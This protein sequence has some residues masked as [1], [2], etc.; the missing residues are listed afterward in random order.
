[1]GGA[2][3]GGGGGHD[4]RMLR[5][6]AG[7]VLAW[8]V[9][10][11]VRAQEFA[12]RLAEAASAKS[13]LGEAREGRSVEGEPLMVGDVDAES[14]I[15]THAPAEIVF[16]V[17]PGARWFTCWFGVAAE[18]GENGSIALEVWVDGER[19]HVSPVQRGGAAPVWVAVP[20]DG[21]KELKLVVTDGGDGNGADHGNLLWPRWSN[22]KDRPAP[23]QPVAITFAGQTSVVG[24][25]WSGRPARRFVEAYPLGDGRLGAV[26]YGGVARDR[27]VLNEITM[28]SGSVDPG[29]DRVG[30]NQ[31]LPRIRELLAAG[32][33]VEAERL[34]NETFTCAGAGS[35][36][37]KGKDLPYGCYQVLGD[38]EITWL[39]QDGKPLHGKVHGYGRGLRLPGE[40]LDVPASQNVLFELP[41]GIRHGRHLS[42]RDGVVVLSAWSRQGEPAFDLQLRRRER[43]TVRAIGDDGLELRG[44]L[45][46]GRGGD[47]VHFAARVQVVGA[48][49]TR[50]VPAG[51][52]VT[53]QVRGSPPGVVRPPSTAVHV[54]I[55][56][57]TDFRS[58]ITAAPQVQG[59]GP[60]PVCDPEFD[61]AIER[62]LQR[63]VRNLRADLSTP[64]AGRDRT[65]L[66]LGGRE[67][68]AVPT[69]QR[70]ADLAAGGADPDL[71]A[72]YFRYGRFLLRASS[73]PGSLP[74][75][76]QGLWAP[77]YQTP[78]NGDH[79]LDVNV[80]M[81]YWPALTANLIECDEPLTRLIE[82]LVEPGRRT[83]KVYYGAPGWVAHA[84]TNVWGFT[85]PGEH[86]S[87]GATNSGSGWL[88][89]HLFEHWAFTQDNAYLQRVYPIMKESAQ[90]YL[91]T[92]VREPKHGWLVTGVS[93]SP[94]N[95]FRTPDG[96]VAHVCMGPTV[97]QQI[98]RELFGNVIEAAA[99]LGVDAGF[100]RQLAEARERLAPHRIGRHGQLQ[101]WLEDF[102]EVEPHHRHVA[103]L[104]GL[105]P[106]DQITPI[107]TPE[108]AAAARV[109][110]QRRGDD[111]TG[112]ALAQKAAMWARLHDGDHALLL[113]T[114]LLRPT[115][116]LGFDMHRG[117]TYPNLLCAHPPFQIDGNLGGTA[118]IAEMLLQSHRERS[119]E[120][121][122]LHLLPALPTQWPN[123][124]VTGLRARGN[125]EVDQHWRDGALREARLTRVAGEHTHIRI[126]CRWPVT[127]RLRDQPIQPDA[128][129]PHVFTLPLRPGETIVLTT[130][131]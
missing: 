97:D 79:H 36:H 6:I 29:A 60:Q 85:S 120:D 88:C 3:G 37:G 128:V 74:A 75:N 16:A 95:A 112:W 87:W 129:A 22:G 58:S 101:E 70:L 118:A 111:G 10:L 80:Q 98:V 72:L 86:A 115:G 106:G 73:R 66:D 25:L 35:G 4:G 27:L 68:A 52:G 63:A 117:G 5:G 108:L 45:G 123:G 43:A 54:L 31:A 44:A 78:W 77:E 46:D 84:I 59:P 131:H 116:Q 71:F 110:L 122:T 114:R 23:V 91:A 130:D 57:G 102:D 82:S 121:Y 30:A 34:V 125:V 104:Y 93:N 8:S 20:V 19:R 124:K 47:G 50:V 41:E 96:Q 64:R 7:F 12:L 105:Y 32:E 55:A 113:L 14:G 103:H 33:H 83:A 42:I 107:G 18:R 15:G 100:A 53:L 81:N 94:E 90:F 61:A 65:T 92:L 13:A 76:L 62:S 26:W 28:W 69:A 56:A 126:R 89:R 1:M 24:D 21:A 39:G 109:S 127:A 99:M 2:A 17:R 119:G 51:L 38:L 40:R 9:A 11:P 48:G 49:A 67:R